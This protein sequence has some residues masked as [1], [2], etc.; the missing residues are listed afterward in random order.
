MN[1]AFTIVSAHQK[2]HLAWWVPLC[3]G[4]S[5]LTLMTSGAAAAQVGVSISPTSATLVTNATQLF[6]ATVT[7]SSDTAVI[8]QVNA[9][10]GG[11]S[12]VGTIATTGL[13]V[14]PPSVPNPG[15]VTVTAISQAD[16][17]KSSSATITIEAASRSGVSYYVSSTGSDTSGAGTLASPWRTIQHAANMVRAGDTVNIRGGTYNESVTIGAS[18]SVSA[19]LITFQGYP[20]ETAVVD[21]TG[22]SV[23]NNQNGLINIVNQSYLLIQGLEI[24]NYKSTRRNVVPVGIWVTG[25]GSNLQFL[26]NHIHDITVT[27]TGCNANALGFAIYGTAAPASLNNITVSGNQIDHL[28]TG[29]SESLTLDGNVETFAI[30]NNQVHDNNNI[31]IDL[32]GFEGVS[33][34][35]AYDQARNGLVSG[36][37]VYNITSNGNPSYSAGCWCADG[38]YVDGGMQILVERNLI[39]NVDLGIEMASEHSG[40]NASYITARDNL[41]YFGNSAGLSI[42]GYASGVGGSDHITIVN[43]T[44]FKNDGK[45]TGSGEFQIQYHATNNLFENNIAY[46]GS[47]ALLV[48]DYTSS[49]PNP[50][51]LNYNVYYATSGSS[52]STFVW[53]HVTHTTYGT[54]LSSSGQDA[55]SVFVDPKF[56]NPAAPDLH[57]LSSSPAVNAGTNLG[58]SIVGTVDYAG[59]PRV[60]GANIDVGAYEQ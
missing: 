21:G 48:N 59:N 42:G 33:P 39:H 8:W 40:K 29:C 13:Y 36:N 20:G 60:E 53:Q 30:V 6:N 31:G 7:G 1:N 45:K 51:V 55:K 56:V 24:R 17:T 34:N 41:I 11:N 14:G 22:L 58:S 26:N 57:V 23:P 2:Y 27:A 47:Q 35:P 54:Y 19:G 38:I 15:S 32:I 16:P 43:N 52:N 25:A 10:T 28:K 50:C 44:L 18:G 12:S 37:G 3:L 4:S 5:F 9:V 46:A 49:T